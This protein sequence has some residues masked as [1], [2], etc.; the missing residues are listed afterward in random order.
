MGLCIFLAIAD[1]ILIS[2]FSLSGYN[3]LSF[4]CSRAPMTTTI[5]LGYLQ[6]VSSIRLLQAAAVDAQLRRFKSKKS[7]ANSH[8]E[9]GKRLDIEQVGENSIKNNKI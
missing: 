7:A 1:E 5:F 6:V 9:M 4:F 3:D 8:T 2:L